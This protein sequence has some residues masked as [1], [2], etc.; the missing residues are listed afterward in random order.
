MTAAPHVVRLRDPAGAESFLCYAAPGLTPDRAAATRFVSAAVAHRA[1]VAAIHGDSD[2]FWPS[3]RESAA[4]TARERRGWT[5]TAEPCEPV[6][7][8]N[9]STADVI[10][11]YQAAFLRANGRAVAVTYERGWFTVEGLFRNSYR[12]G[13]LLKATDTLNARHGVRV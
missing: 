11:A 9:P 12:R 1:A 5:A 2:A 13:E 4:R 10:A 3:E 6:T 8:T 7:V